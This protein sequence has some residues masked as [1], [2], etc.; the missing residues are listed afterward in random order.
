VALA[1][2]AGAAVLATVL[3]VLLTTVRAPGAEEDA[4]RDD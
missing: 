1:V 4:Y 3:A 2:T